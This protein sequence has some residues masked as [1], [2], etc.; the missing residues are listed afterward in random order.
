MKEQ[1]FELPDSFIEKGRQLLI[2]ADANQWA[3]GEHILDGIA[4]FGNEWDRR[5]IKNG[6]AK[7]IRQLSNKL[8]CDESTLR[9]RHNVVAFWQPKMKAEYQAF[10]W[11]QLRAIKHAG[12]EWEQYATWALEHLP[13]P[14]NVIRQQI[15]H[16]HN[17]KPAWMYWWERALDAINRLWHDSNTP[18]EIR[19]MIEDLAA[20]DMV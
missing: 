1:T 10:S 20:S 2:N 14:P 7:L 8:G 18:Q 13:C 12:D 19:D 6:R 11:S 9:D 4:E 16:D 17:G 3:I 5:G 15:A